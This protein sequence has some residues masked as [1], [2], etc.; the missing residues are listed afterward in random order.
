MQ[1]FSR[2]K[3]RSLLD[4]VLLSATIALAF[5]IST[6]DAA[7]ASRIKDLVSVEGIRENQLIG[8]GLVVG[9]N[10]TGDTLRN[11]PFT[12]QSLAAMLERLGINAKGTEMKPENTAAVLVTANLPPFSRTGTKIDV[13]VSSMGDAQDLKGGTLLATPLMGYD[14]EVYAVA[15]GGVAVAGFTAQGDAAT[16]VQGVPTNGRIANGGIVEKEVSFELSDLTNVK[17]SLHNPDLTTARRIT[18]A[19]NTQFGGNMARMM[20]PSTI[21]I[22]R[23]IGY[24][25]RLVDMLTD[26]EQL[27]VTPDTKAQVIIDERTGIIVMGSEVRISPVAI[28][29]GNLTIRITET[30]QVSQPNAFGGGDTAVVPRTQV[31]A[32]TGGD[33]KLAVLP[34]AVS[35]QELVNGL[36]ALGIGPR[37]MI[38][39]LQAIK[40]AGAMQAEIKVM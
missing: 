19:I 15:Q 21:Q 28:A 30:P 32:D 11:A 5:I 23:P 16:I 18:A 14:G 40:A 24:E 9:L 1:M 37:E 7:A 10:G 26:I 27:L 22:D 17:L 25:S 6:V 36:N 38:S 31:T 2:K 3:S 35:L 20:D 34:E 4:A 29:Q 33:R 12:E 39:I 13:T 8:Y